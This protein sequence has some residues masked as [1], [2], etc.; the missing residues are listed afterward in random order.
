MQPVYV[1]PGP[2]EDPER[3]NEEPTVEALLLWA[4]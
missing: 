4:F 2:A 3:L 1:P